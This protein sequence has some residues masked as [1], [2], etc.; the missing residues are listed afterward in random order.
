MVDADMDFVP[1]PSVSRAIIRYNESHFD[2][3]DGI[4]ITPSHNPP[5]NGGIKYNA[6]NGGPADTLITKW[7]ETRANEYVRA[8]CELE[9]L[10]RISIDN[11]EP[12]Q[13]VPYDYKGFIC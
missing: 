3:A 8:Y 6:T 5:D 4:V 7:I 10:K 13:Q 2:K 12:D 1:T 11:I 9:G